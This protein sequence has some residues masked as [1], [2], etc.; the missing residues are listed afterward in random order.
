MLCLGALLG[1]GAGS[2]GSIAIGAA[3]VLLVLIGRPWLLVG[4]GIG[5]VRIMLAPLTPPA[6]DIARAAGSPVTVEGTVAGYPERVDGMQRA[7]V[8]VA[9][10]GTGRIR[11]RAEPYPEL[12]TG[13]RV[14]LTG[15]LEQPPRFPDFDYRSYL[16]KDGIHSLLNR[17]RIDVV[18]SPAGPALALAQGRERF[19]AALG[20]AFPEPEASVLSGILVGER[21][22]L[23]DSLETTFQRTGT[24]HLLALSG[25]NVSIVLGVAIGILGRR[26]FGIAVAVGLL[27]LFVLFVGPSAS[28]VRAALMGGF[29]LLGQALG[30]PQAALQG[31]VLM[32][33]LMLMASPWSLRYDLGFDLSFLATAGILLWQPA[34]RDW[35]RGR[36]PRLLCEPLSVTVAAS[37][38]TAPLIAWTFGSVSLISPVANLVAVPLVPWLMAGAFLAGIAG[39]VN[40][41]LGTLAGVL[42]GALARLLVYILEWCSSLPSAAITNQAARPI[43]TGLAALPLLVLANKSRPKHA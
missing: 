15:R 31:C 21:T 41:Q 25:Y 6:D 16:A 8:R 5:F 11:V 27:G 29:L 7:V 23:P 24:T 38:P 28:V 13:Q 33:A 4:F 40:D 32:A 37:L 10:P 3:G 20:R 36:V 30:R 39:M 1:V 26:P 18:E 35:L 19:L 12:H 14:R 42:P 2:F 9:G 17:P 34:I 43:L 22:G